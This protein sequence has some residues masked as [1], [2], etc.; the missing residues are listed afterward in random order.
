[1]CRLRR[2]DGFAFPNR[3]IP[4]E[5]FESEVVLA[6]TRRKLDLVHSPRTA[7][8]YDNSK[9]YSHLVNATPFIGSQSLQVGWIQHGYGALSQRQ[10]GFG[11]F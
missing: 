11:T 5:Q 8:E 1:M 4:S 9:S 3:N 7:R 10:T 2:W 6:P